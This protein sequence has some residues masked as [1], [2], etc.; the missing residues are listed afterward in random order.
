M[1]DPARKRVLVLYWYNRHSPTNI[2]IER[3]LLPELQSARPAIEY[4]SE[5]LESDR[6][7]G[8]RQARVLH[9]FL[10]QKYADVPI[11]VVVASGD[12]THELL[13]RHR[14][15]LFPDAALVFIANPAISD[16]AVSGH[17]G[18]A[19]YRNY[20]K[21]IELI[22]RLHP[23]ANHVYI[24]SG[25]VDGD[26]RFAPVARA[27]LAANPPGI[28]VTYLTDVALGDLV[29]RARALPRGSVI[30]FVW[31][32][33]TT[34][35]GTVLEPAQ[36]LSAITSSS[37]VPVHVMSAA[38]L[39]TGAVG[40]DVFTLE[41]VGKRAAQLALRVV[42]GT[43]PDDITMERPPSVPTFDWR[44]LRRLGIP[45]SRLPAGSVVQFRRV[46]I[47]DQ[48]RWYIVGILAFIAAQAA[49]IVALVMQRASRQRAE[50]SARD[51]RRELVHLNRVATVGELAGT[52][53]HELGQP[54][55]AI[56]VNAMT[57]HAMLERETLDRDELRGV[58]ADIM[59]NDRMAGDMITRVRQALRHNDGTREDLDVNQVIGGALSFLSGEFAA[60]STT[61]TTELAP[62]LPRVS[63][64]RVELQQ[65]MI[66]LVL[67]A[68]DAMT[69]QE[70]GKRVLTLR[71]ALTA[72]GTVQVSVTDQGPGIRADSM[73]RIFTAFFT[74]KEHG[75]GL[76]LSICRRIISAHGGAIW[77]ENTSD[78]GATFVFHLPARPA[79]ADEARSSDRPAAPRSEDRPE[80]GAEPAEALRDRQ[81]IHRQADRPVE[82]DAG[83]AAP[84]AQ[85][86]RTEDQR[87]A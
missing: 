13:V 41:A 52:L 21:N 9:D 68:C 5:Y 12:A 63:A 87:S 40:G 24:V 27:E 19:P 78:G 58:I 55:G 69:D 80:R 50:L 53:A 25:T 83:N 85:R 10:K 34:D 84:R 44:E 57:A 29:A 59:V 49:L 15:T 70:P 36:V 74:T 30:L 76:G 43:R 54:L 35:D 28:N 56:R 18:I 4:Y 64:D 75:L 23:Q 73:D 71:T 20:S 81:D 33:L 46:T 17:T 1:L 47:W 79:A 65:V 48:Y 60:R 11:D 3:G 2:G 66:N 8:E 14:R 42:S 7:P 62:G 16:T 51:Q 45:E 77:A 86:Q 31:Q 72:A 39:G 61:V 6:F 37:A 67:N 22:R 26:K 32:Q 38:R 82:E